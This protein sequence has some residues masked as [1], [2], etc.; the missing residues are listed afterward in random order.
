[1][2]PYTK[3]LSVDTLPVVDVSSARAGYAVSKA[4]AALAI[5]RACIDT[6]FFY[7][8]NHGVPPELV[9]AQFQ[10]SKRFFDLTS[11]QKQALA[12][13]RSPFKRGYEGPS[14]QVLDDGSAPDLK[15]SFRCGLA[16]Q[17][18]H[19]Y[20][21][22]GLPTY[23]PS[24]WPDGLP[25]FR[26]QME[27]YA[28]ALQLLGDRLLSLI[29]LSLDLDETFFAAHYRTP[30]A[31]VRLLTYPPQPRAGSG[32]LLGAGAHT[33]WGGI[34]ILAQDDLG[35]LEV[36]NVD[37]QW[38]AARPIADTFV[39][40]IG[41]MLSRWTNQRYTSNMHRV[42]NNSSTQLRYSVAFFYD[43]DYFARIECLPTCLAPGETPREPPCTS[44]EHI[45]EMHRRT[46]VPTL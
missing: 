46:S 23:G 29:A 13:S 9:R 15:E 1:M 27:A 26:E 6:G 10:W 2:I 11:S 20:T 19:P 44:G 12:Q 5:R 37:G 4:S 16:P 43:P 33:D 18:D 7:I 42:R 3:P 24:Q 39:V 35:G 36:R 8:V 30:M 21:A 25:G 22:K 38:I 34:T 41:E 17:P 40:N 31:T 28:C 32:N 45:A 14:A